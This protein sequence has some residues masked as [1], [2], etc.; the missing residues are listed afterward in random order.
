MKYSLLQ[1]RWIFILLSFVLFSPVW[2]WGNTSVVSLK[3]QNVVK[4]LAVED[5]HPVFSWQ[6]SSDERGQKQSAYQIIVTRKSDG[7]V[8]WDSRKVESGVSTQV[9]YQGVALQ[10]EMAYEWNL[11]VWDAQGKSYAASSSFETGLMNP[12]ISAWNGAEWIGSKELRLDA[13]ATN[14]FMIST[15]F[16][17]LKGDKASFILGANDFRL[18]DS[19]QNA[20][21]LE[22]ENYV[23]IELDLSGVGSGRGAVLHIYRVG[24]AQ[25]DRADIPFM[26]VSAEK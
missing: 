16:R 5:R 20:D 8:V 14:Y 19:F 24:Y 12:H 22:G 7:R 11:T 4:P 23:R 13:T 10:P 17:L 25:G 9:K 18:I 3:V 26:T 1:L 21:N 15:Q 2:T 6:M